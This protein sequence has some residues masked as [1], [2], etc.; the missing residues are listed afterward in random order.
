MDVSWDSTGPNLNDVHVEDVQVVFQCSPARKVMLT[1]RVSTT[2]LVQGESL[3]EC[4][5]RW[6]MLGTDTAASQRRT[7][8]AAG[9]EPGPPVS[10]GRLAPLGPEPPG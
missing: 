2:Q 7:L 5:L 8:W 3:T 4:S 6:E 9:M 1:G 10:C